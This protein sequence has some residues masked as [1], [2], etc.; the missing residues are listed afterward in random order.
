MATPQPVAPA[1]APYDRITACRICGDE[2]LATVL[3]LGEQALG[4][5]FPTAQEPTPARVPLELARCQG[6]GLV[7]LRHTTRPDALYTYDYGYRSGTNASMRNHLAG[8]AAWIEDRCPLAAGDVVLDIGCNDGTLL[9]AYRTP[10]LRRIG[11]DPIV[12]KFADH[13]ETDITTIEGFFSPE[14]WHRAGTGAPARVITSISMFYDLDDPNAFAAAIEQAL[15]EDGIWVMEQSYLPA[16]LEANAFD[17]ICHEH[18]EY[19]A[20]SQIE[21]IARAHGLR[22]FDAERNACNGGSFRL[23]LCRADGPYA[24]NGEALESL[25]ALERDL[26]LT[27]EA[28]YRAFAER[29]A[30]LRMRLRRFV[31][32]AHAAGK[33]I[34]LYGASTKGNT[35]LQYFG[36]DH[37][38][39]AA[40][41]ERNPQKWGRRTPGTDIPIVSEDDMRRARPDYLLV[42]PWH[43]RD[44]FIS[45]EADYLKR[46]GQFIFPL[47]EMEI[48]ADPGRENTQ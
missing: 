27:T 43:F 6:C 14:T 9:K 35:L 41:A 36:L 40:A 33:T 28:P 1:E 4:S 8:L 21:W 22:V 38:R 3:D 45:R 10:G 15:A 42:L 25:R 5:C 2:A 47:P 13:F 39:I 26:A 24:E 48:V 12:G 11:I 29:I 17:T 46:G 23:A 30:A 16:M 31:E 19:Y 20:L 44:E 32:D 37:T 34:Y 18:L 7:Q